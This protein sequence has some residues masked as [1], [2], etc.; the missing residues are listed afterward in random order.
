MK[1]CIKCE[2]DLEYNKFYSNRNVCI[3]CFKKQVH[4]SRTDYNYDAGLIPVPETIET[5]VGK[6]QVNP[7][8]YN[9]LLQ[10]RK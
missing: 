2:E 10:L 5:Y 6:I 1:Q 9:H 4:A 8:L 3:K 7:L